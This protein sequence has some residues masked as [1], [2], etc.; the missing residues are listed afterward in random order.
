MERFRKCPATSPSGLKMI[1]WLSPPAEFAGYYNRTSAGGREESV[2]PWPIGDES[3][4]LLIHGCGGRKEMRIAE[5]TQVLTEVLLAHSR[6]TAGGG[7]NVLTT[8]CSSYS[9]SHAPTVSGEN[10]E[11]Y[12]ANLKGQ[13]MAPSLEGVLLHRGAVFPRPR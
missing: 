6:C 3:G 1:R 11:K 10:G 13:S 5:L 12:S 9:V 2:P 7:S 4:G 8:Y